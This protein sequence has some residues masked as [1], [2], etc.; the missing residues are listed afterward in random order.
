MNI[1]Q[2]TAQSRCHR[3]KLYECYLTKLVQNNNQHFNDLRRLI[4][5]TK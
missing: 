5:L 2:S 3:V 4:E 1:V